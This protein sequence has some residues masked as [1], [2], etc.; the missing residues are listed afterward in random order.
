MS[1]P[2]LIATVACTV[3]QDVLVQAVGQRLTPG[4]SAGERDGQAVRSV[5]L[6]VKPRDAEAIELASSMGRPR[7]V[8][9]GPNDRADSKSD[10]VSFVELRGEDPGHV[11]TQVVTVA[12]VTP[13]TAVAST[14]PTARPSVRRPSDPFAEDLKP[15]RTVNLIRGSTKTEVVFELPDQ[16]EANG[17]FTKTSNEPVER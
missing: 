1:G 3:V 13:V 8:L 4:P 12:P 9:R 10:G 14:Q 7:L 6:V 11:K 5:T 15:R 16:P 17:V 2:L